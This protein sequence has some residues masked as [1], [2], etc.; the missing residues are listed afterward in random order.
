MKLSIIPILSVVLI[1]HGCVQKKTDEEKIRAKSLVSLTSMRKGTMAHIEPLP[2]IAQYLRHTTVETPI[3][4][5]IKFVKINFNDRV[6]KGQLLYTIETKERRAL[7]NLGSD[8]P[9]DKNY[10]LVNVYAPMDGV[11]TSL[12]Q[13]QPGIFVPEAAVLCDITD[14]KSLYFQVN[15]PYEYNRYIAENTSGKIILPDGTAFNARL[16][17]PVIQA[18]TGL[19]TIPYMAKLDNAHYIPS[20]T[21]AK[22]EMV[23]YKNKEALLLPKKAVLSD[24]LM[25]KFWVMKLVNDSLAIKVSIQLGDQDS[26]MIEIKNPKFTGE[27]RIL[28]SGNYGLGDSALVSIK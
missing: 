4:G 23:L 9:L 5:T 19:Q 8:I 13:S 16:Q 22:F 20:G 18:I 25:E 15:I 1:L 6:H 12:P 27:D 11:V 21:I 28:V 14:E 10:G 7:G 24:E 3:A 17:T 26:E 2:S